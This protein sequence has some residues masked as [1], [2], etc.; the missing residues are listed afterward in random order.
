M[1]LI[2]YKRQTT[3]NKK[4]KERI[5]FSR[6]AMFLVYFNIKQKKDYLFN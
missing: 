2:F 1:V 5:V 6:E 3:E 4:L